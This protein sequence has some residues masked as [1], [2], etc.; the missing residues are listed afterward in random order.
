M[1]VAMSL[2]LVCDGSRA[3]A[4]SSLQQLKRKPLLPALTQTATLFSRGVVCLQDG[5]HEA[6]YIG[7][8]AHRD[9]YRVGD[10]IMK[11]AAIA[12]DNQYCSN[13]MEAEALKSTEALEQTPRLF[14]H[15]VCC[16]KSKQCSSSPVKCIT[17]T[18]SCILTTYAGPSLD[19]LMYSCFGVPYDHTVA[20]F[21]VSAYQ[22]L[23]V[24]C[25]DGRR[26]MIAYSD[27]HSASVNTS[28]DPIDHV[29]GQRVPCMIGNAERLSLG[30]Y[31]RSVFNAVCD[32]M[33]ADFE[34]QCSMA[35]DSSW[36]F[37]APL[38]NQHLG[39]FFRLRGKLEVDVLRDTFLNRIDL[40]WR[41]IC[42]ATAGAGCLPPAD[43]RSPEAAVSAAASEHYA[44][45]SASRST[46]SSER[47]RLSCGH[48]F[49]DLREE[50]GVCQKHY[51]DRDANMRQRHT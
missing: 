8:G 39:R 32:T 40:V 2:Q 45:L 46:S 3:E 7:R 10:V 17:Q 35:R 37:I 47:L 42:K 23:G 20:N 9:V 48:F 6:C 18:V 43:M 28:K 38:I 16:I 24:M 51:A 34:L 11:L 19:E 49:D 30:E 13:F 5:E 50:C 15:G 21:F 44:V 41:D 26:L 31:T 27:L 22:E 1:I 29:I 25:I 36:K 12:T 14:F 33:I 4:V